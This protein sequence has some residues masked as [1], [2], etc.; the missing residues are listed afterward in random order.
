VKQVSVNYFNKL[1]DQKTT[2]TKMLV[3]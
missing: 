3:S 2:C 1:H